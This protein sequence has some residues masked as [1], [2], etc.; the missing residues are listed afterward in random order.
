MLSILK[1]QLKIELFMYFFI[2]SILS[3]KNKL[4]NELVFSPS[5]H[6]IY[7]YGNSLEIFLFLYFLLLNL[8]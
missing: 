7:Q 5:V 4:H 8:T 6:L 3:Q 2:F 1:F